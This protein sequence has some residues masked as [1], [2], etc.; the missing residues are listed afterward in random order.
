MR[1]DSRDFLSQPQ[2]IVDA[3]NTGLSQ[4]QW[5]GLWSVKSGEVD[6]ENSFCMHFSASP[7]EHAPQVWIDRLLAEKE[8]VETMIVLSLHNIAKLPCAVAISRGNEDRQFDIAVTRS[9]PSDPRP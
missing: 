3:I 8:T 4:W 6:P 1:E 7:A 5:Y 9:Q 2:R